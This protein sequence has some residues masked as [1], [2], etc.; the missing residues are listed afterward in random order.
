MKRKEII[1]LEKKKVQKLHTKFF[2]KE[3]SPCKRKETT[4]EGVKKILP[5]N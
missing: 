3:F 4:R 1:G 5:K 2:L